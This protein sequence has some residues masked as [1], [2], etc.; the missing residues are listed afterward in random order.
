[1]SLGKERQGEEEERDRDEAGG[2]GGGVVV[3]AW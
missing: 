3:S 2:V 1:M